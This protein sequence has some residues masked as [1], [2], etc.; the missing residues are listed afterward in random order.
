MTSSV[1]NCG[2]SGEGER[3]I[4]E[5]TYRIRRTTS[6]L[7]REVPALQTIII[8]LCSGPLRIGDFVG[9][10]PKRRIPS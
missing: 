6:V 5:Q 3:G 7:R 2:E 1:R 8:R 4:D 10:R 9:V